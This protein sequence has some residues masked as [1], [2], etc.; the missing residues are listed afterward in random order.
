MNPLLP[1]P[2]QVQDVIQS[3]VKHHQSRTGFLGPPL[4]L[5]GMDE[6]L[7]VSVPWQESI[8]HSLGKLQDDTPDFIFVPL[9]TSLSESELKMRLVTAS[10]RVIRVNRFPF[11]L[12]EIFFFL[13]HITIPPLSPKAA[14]NF[15]SISHLKRHPRFVHLVREC[16]GV[17]RHLQFL[18]C[19]IEVCVLSVE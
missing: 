1:G 17:P 6:I 19:A 10:G 11:F 5:F 12:S 2:V 4:V 14:L 16:A 18:K 7:K 3:I 13:Q 8:V 9:V 15:F